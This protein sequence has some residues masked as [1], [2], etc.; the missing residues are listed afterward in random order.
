MNNLY[1]RIFLFEPLVLLF[2]SLI[3]FFDIWGVD[4]ITIFSVCV[5]VWGGNGFLIVNSKTYFFSLFF[6]SLV[7]VCVS[8]Y[9]YIY[10]YMYITPG[11]STQSVGAVEYIYCISAEE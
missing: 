8:I 6:F 11:W 3:L 1:K 5:C 7:V 2:W 10:I 9:I 4:K